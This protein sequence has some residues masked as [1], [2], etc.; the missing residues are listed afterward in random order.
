MPEKNTGSR[1]KVESQENA[2]RATLFG[3][4]GEGTRG[5]KSGDM[6]NGH[7]HYKREK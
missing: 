2:F 5:G 4:S 1:D 3:L 7:R 6:L